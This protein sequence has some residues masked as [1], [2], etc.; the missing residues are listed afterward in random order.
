MLI[1]IQRLGVLGEDITMHISVGN[2]TQTVTFALGIVVV[3][4]ATVITI[5]ML[6]V[7]MHVSQ[8]EEMHLMLSQ[9][10]TGQMV[11]KGIEEGILMMIM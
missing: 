9:I 6:D 5:K 8:I 7:I 11:R 3:V 4:S 1:V 10:H 2:M